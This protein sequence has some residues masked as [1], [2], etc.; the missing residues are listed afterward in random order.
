MRGEASWI[1]ASG[2]LYPRDSEFGRGNLHSSVQEL[3]HI[4]I[5]GVHIFA[6]PC[7]SIVGSAN[8]CSAIR[9]VVVPIVPITLPYTLRR[10]CPSELQG[11]VKELGHNSKDASSYQSSMVG[12]AG[13][14]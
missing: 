5:R 10:P 11:S 1:R 6:R 13:D 14:T 4:A 12:T 2:A 7:P 9:F 3:Q 8:H